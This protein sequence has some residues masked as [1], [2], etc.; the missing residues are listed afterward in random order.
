MSRNA[1]RGKLFA[2]WCT[3]LSA[4]AAYGTCPRLFSAASTREVRQRRVNVERIMSC[5]LRAPGRL[6]SAMRPY[7][8]VC[9][10]VLDAV[11]SR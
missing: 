5:A 10:R 4:W 1:K 7:G 8:G 11:P 3:L 9:D 6:S 2:S